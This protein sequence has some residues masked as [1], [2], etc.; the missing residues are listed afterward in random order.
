MDFATIVGLG[1]GMLI[2]TG[3]IV[4][5]GD[6]MTFVNL[7]SIL[8]VLGGGLAATVLRFPLNIIPSAFATGGKIAF[9]QK[10]SSPRAMIDEITKLAEIVRKS[11]PLGLESVEIS[12]DFL[13]K[14]VQYVADGYEAPFILESLERERDLMLERLQDSQKIFKAL[15]DAAPAFGLI[16]TLVGLVQLL[17]NMDDPSKIGPAMAVALLTTLYGAL[18]ANL[19]CLPIAD[20]LTTKSKIESINL[21]LAIDGIMQLREN[22]SPDLIRE[23]L[24]AYLPEKQRVDANAEAA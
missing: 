11:G 21:T 5:G 2:V 15:G 14:G 24:V 1:V 16:G 19:I 20:K 7:P 8:I 23:M 18:I 17:S 6:F 4:M 22:K 12:E 13:K 3:A 9:T 10:K